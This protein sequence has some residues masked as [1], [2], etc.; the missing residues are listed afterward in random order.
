MTTPP[1]GTP[2]DPR[3]PFVKDP[4]GNL[5]EWPKGCLPINPDSPPGV[6]RHLTKDSLGQ[7][8]AALQAFEQAR[9]VHVAQD[10]QYSDSAQVAAQSD[11]LPKAQRFALRAVSWGED[12]GIDTGLELVDFRRA[13]DGT[14]M[15]VSVLRADD[16]GEGR[17]ATVEAAW[18]GHY[19]ADLGDHGILPDDPDDKDRVLTQVDQLRELTVQA[20][21]EPWKG[22]QMIM[23]CLSEGAST[24][25]A[26][27]R[28]L[29]G[30][31]QDAARRTRARITGRRRGRP[32]S[33]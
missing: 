10:P 31:L 15:V 5:I 13:S 12:R 6:V 2:E 22:Y 28:G 23:D 29:P 18:R 4:Q 33:S 25:Q 8:V 14:E 11:P 19:L 27:R 32:G 17:Y 30:R 16:P 21:V 24:P 26:D 3:D 20:G 1:S 9:L 7:L